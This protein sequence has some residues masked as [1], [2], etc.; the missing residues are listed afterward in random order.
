M[1]YAIL[2]FIILVKVLYC[3]LRAA[4]DADDTME[5]MYTES[6]KKEQD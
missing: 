5:R 3:L 2:L 4:S 6:K 1:I